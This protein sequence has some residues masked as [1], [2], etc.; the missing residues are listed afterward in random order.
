MDV[1]T[2]ARQRRSTRAFLDSQLS[3]SD[4]RGWMADAQ[5]APSGGNMQPWRVIALAGDAKDRVIATAMER[6]PLVM[7]AGEETDKPV[8]PVD[9]PE[10][11]ATRRRETG[12]LMYD[13]LGIERGD[14]AKFAA[15][16]ANNFRFFGAPVAL[17]FVMDEVM[18][19]GQFAH[20]G[21]YMQT[22]AL[23]AE[24]RGWAT[25]M[26]E[27]WGMLRPTLHTHLGLADNEVVY[28]GMAVGVPDPNHPINNYRT[29]RA[30]IDDVVDF[31]G[32]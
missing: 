18:G 21:M 15:W 29:P 25:C 5:R 23:L 6:V 1:T 7:P 4:L 22:L 8:Y 9:L 10:L 19:H 11:Y 2:A 30:D 16:R 3:E 24:E 14:E 32:F 27:A 28:C 13:A 12:A 20:L 17:I 31:R 26:Q